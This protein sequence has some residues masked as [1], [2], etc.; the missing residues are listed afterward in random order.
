MRHSYAIPGSVQIDDKNRPL[1]EF[2]KKYLSDLLQKLE[3]LKSQWDIHLVMYSPALRTQE[4]MNALRS[5]Y[6]LKSSFKEEKLF[7]TGDLNQ[8]I[9]CLFAL[10]NTYETILLIGHNPYWEDLASQ[11]TGTKI[12]LEPAQC[13]FLQKHI[14]SWCDLF[15]GGY[16]DL[17]KNIH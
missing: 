2:G 5:F 17:E 9:S 11:L 8:I 3:V 14:D 6:S 1:S 4:T 12:N 7:Y 13:V 10:E 16:W 15:V